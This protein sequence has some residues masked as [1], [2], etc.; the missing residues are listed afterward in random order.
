MHKK[1]LIHYA[2][3]FSSINDSI[4]LMMAWYFTTKHQIRLVQSDHNQQVCMMIP[5]AQP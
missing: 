1:L 5:M 2:D 4:M 3:F